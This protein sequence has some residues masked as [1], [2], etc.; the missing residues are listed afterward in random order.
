M[1][2]EH[3]D[4]ECK[5]PRGTRAPDWHGILHVPKTMETARNSRLRRA[6]ARLSG[7]PHRFMQ[8]G[9]TVDPDGCVLPKYRNPKAT[10]RNLERSYVD[11]LDDGP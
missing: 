8:N 11:V 7:E 3:K 5:F 1:K 2:T 4:E 9:E 6:R 10:Q